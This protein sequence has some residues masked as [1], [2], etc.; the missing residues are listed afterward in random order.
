MNN[1]LFYIL[2][3]LILLPFYGN[4]SNWR[5]HPT[6]DE[7]VERVIDTPDF[8]Y[9]T[10]RTLPSMT[11]RENVYSLF[12]YDKGAQELRTLSTDNILSS[13]NIS[14]LQYCPEKGYL[15][16][17]HSNF[18]ID[19]LYDN[20]KAE[21]I[22]TYRLASFSGSKK[23]NAITTDPEN[24][25]FYL[26]TNFGYVTFNDRKLEIAES[27]NY[28]EPL[29]SFLRINDWY[30][31][32]KDNNLLAAPTGDQRSTLDDYKVIASFESPFLMTPLGNDK[33]IILSKDGSPDSLWII[34]EN[35]GEFSIKKEKDEYFY[36]IENNSNGI[37][38][39]TGVMVYEYAKDGSVD[40]VH[41]HTDDARISVA[42][43]DFKEFWYGDLRKGLKG[44]KN[45]SGI[46]TMTSDYM[47]PDSPSPFISTD[48]AMHPDHGLLIS[49]FGWDYNLGGTYNHEFPLLLSGHKNQR[50][51]YLSPAYTNPEQTFVMKSPNGFAIDPDNRDLLYFT[52]RTGGIV[53]LNLE[54]PEDI[55]HL[56]H[57][58]D[59]A[60]GL[61]GFY[62]WLPSQSSSF[63]PCHFSAP[64][65]DS[66]GNLWMSYYDVDNQSE[67]A[68]HFYVWTPE[69]RKASTSK[70]NVS[71]PQLLKVKGQEPFPIGIIL[72]LNY[73]S[74]RN[75]ILYARRNASEAIVILDHNGTPLDPSDDKTYTL[76]SFLDRDG[77]TLDPYNIRCMWED[78]L[79]GL[80]WVGHQSGVF[81]FDP[82]VVLA[83][84]R[85]VTRIKVSR[86]DGTNLADYLLEGV[87]VNKITNDSQGRKWFATGGAGVVC[88]SSDGKEIVRELNTSNSPIPADV[89]FGLGF[90]TESNSMMISTEM[91]LAEYFI[92]GL[93]SN[94]SKPDIKAYPNPV[95]PEYMGFVTIEGI[96]EGSLVKI[97]DASGNIVKELSSSGGEVKWDVSNHSFRRVNSGVYYILVS[98][99]DSDSSF[100]SAGKILVIN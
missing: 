1:K 45:A 79:T 59:E 75:I 88:T 34:E 55:L 16:I 51:D 82:S 80:V 92:P 6:F 46:W 24:D 95:R 89:V 47:L 40:M 21:N 94:S 17:V 44:M 48:M 39:P 72:P 28:E 100:S 71:P 9:F 10:S 27:R 58:G 63:H 42:S 5:M 20:G 77:N 61:P 81:Y 56:S 98:S 4:A 64:R 30:L 96:P 69:A 29:T 54:D 70:D 33:C 8:V 43:Y 67:K 41:R 13:N 7:R 90:D 57:P 87:I 65:F 38:V 76:D 36:N 78:P 99:S 14:Q 3:S 50:W 12:R 68:L 66:K 31:V 25:R 91:G 53:M 37:T 73:S 93:S 74:N 83:G 85:R 11:Q 2:L 32:L 18:D 26:A 19:I 60:A 86:N 49:S 23:V 15:I 62:N 22:P 35:N 52:S 84:D 97:T